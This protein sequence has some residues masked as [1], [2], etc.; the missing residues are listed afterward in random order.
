M[1]I[2]DH[3]FCVFRV[4]DGRPAATSLINDNDILGTSFCHRLPLKF[5][6]DVRAFLHV[7]YRYQGWIETRSDQGTVD[8]NPSTQPI[9]YPCLEQLKCVVW[10]KHFIF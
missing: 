6:M 4:D 9:G 10:M 5:F 1:M 7:M 2:Y 3:T 8:N